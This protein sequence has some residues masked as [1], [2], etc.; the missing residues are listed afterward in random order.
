MRGTT[1]AIRP[2]SLQKA[3]WSFLYTTAAGMFSEEQLS[4]FLH[5]VKHTA[6]LLPDPIARI[7]LLVY[8]LLQLSLRIQ[9][10]QALANAD[11]QEA[12]D[13]GSDERIKSKDDGL[14]WLWELHQQVNRNI[15]DPFI[16]IEPAISSGLTSAELAQLLKVRALTLSYASH[17]AC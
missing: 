5:L 13:S 10:R 9:C 3:V 6:F 17:V 2:A 11:V 12:L 1:A 7:H 15:P 16:F 4:H 8:S 14:V